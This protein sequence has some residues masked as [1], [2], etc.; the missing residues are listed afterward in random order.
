MRELYK[1]FYY[2]ILELAPRTRFPGSHCHRIV[3]GYQGGLYEDGNTAY[4]TKDQHSFIHWLRWKLFG[5]SED[6]RAW[7]MI[8]VGPK[9]LSHEDRV[10]HGKMCAEQ[11]IGMHS[12]EVRKK[13]SALGIKSQEND[14][15][16]T[17]NKQNFY[18]WSTADGRK[19]R[20]SMGG[21]QTHKNGNGYTFREW[22]AEKKTEVAKKASA[23]SGKKPATNGVITK[24]FHTEEER[25]TFIMENPEWRTG[26]HWTRN[27]GKNKQSK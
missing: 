20:A 7:K 4:L 27:S 17:G 6:K 18:Y 15:K 2:N 26:M 5:R 22:P 24:K 13:A 14:Y 21:K 11:N 9:G 8:G 12:P 1:H 10:E 3:P 25:T 16:T 19:E 23:K